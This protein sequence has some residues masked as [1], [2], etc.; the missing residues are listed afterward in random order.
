M[1]GAAS[2]ERSNRRIG[3]VD[4]FSQREPCDHSDYRTDAVGYD[5]KRR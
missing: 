1:N 2:L 5:V 3:G 4:D